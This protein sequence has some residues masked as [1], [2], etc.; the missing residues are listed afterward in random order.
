M[1]SALSEIKQ[2][3]E[4]NHRM[5]EDATT[6]AQGKKSASLWYEVQDTYESSLFFVFD[7]INR[8]L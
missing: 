5:L 1:R 8:K 6:K 4:E 2:A 3:R 7:V